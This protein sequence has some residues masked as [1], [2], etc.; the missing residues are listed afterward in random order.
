M[1]YAEV[2]TGNDKDDASQLAPLL[3]QVDDPIDK[4]SAD[5]AYDRSHCWD[6][7]IIEEI[8]GIIPPR[9]NT[10]YWDDELGQRLPHPRNEILEDIEVFGREGWKHLSDYH[11]RS[12]AETAMF[13]FK[14]IFGEEMKARCEGNQKTETRIKVR[15]I[16]KMTALGMPQSVRVY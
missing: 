10:V 7:L 11:R 13:R 8:Q 15:C 12:M 1:I 16:N 14:T 2:L 4:V 3:E 9:K 5:G 6:V